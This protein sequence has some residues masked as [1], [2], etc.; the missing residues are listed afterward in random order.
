MIQVINIAV[1]KRTCPVCS[2][3]LQEDPQSLLLL[4][5]CRHVVH[6]HCAAGGDQL[7]H[8]PDPALR[9]VGIS[10]GAMGLNGR[11]AL[12]VTSPSFW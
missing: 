7:P 5:L 11:I 2:H 12:L 6:V 1:A 9:V 3:S 8:Q 4:F 10:H